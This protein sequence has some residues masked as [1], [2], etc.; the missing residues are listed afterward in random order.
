[1]K[2]LRYLILALIILNLPAATL[3]FGGGGF[4]SVLSY[5]SLILMMIF[6]MFS[7]K[8]KANVWMLII[9]F[10][11]YLISA[12]QYNGDLKI[13]ITLF[14]KY[15]IVVICG[16]EVIK[17]TSKKELFYF[18]T[19]G[20]LSILIH[21]LFFTSDYGRYSGFYINPNVGGFICITGYGLT[22]GLENK[23]LK[24][25]GQFLFTLMG[26][27]TFSR[28]FIALWLL[29]N[30]L[31]IFISIKNIRI[32]VLG[33]MIM[34]TLFVID[35]FIGLNNPRFQQL[36]AIVSNE[37]VDS[38]A[39]NQGSRTETW[40]RFYDYILDK[41][42]FGNGYGAFQGGGVH[43]LGSHNTYLLVIGESG[44]IPF[45][46][47]IGL[48]LFMLYKGLLLYRLAPNILMQGIGISVFLMANHNFFN[49]YY[50]TFLSMWLQHQ[51]I[52]YDKKVNSTN[53]NLLQ[54]S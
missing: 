38:K 36:K 54:T 17:Q 45:L 12:F 43:R 33:A 37:N 53:N 26:L 52:T 10:S 44:I 11:Y 7:R 48:F 18:L 40:A 13:Y 42:F 30:A 15:F 47:F 14:L 4:G 27:L 20:A 5:A 9:G 6:F 21:T 41:P 34:S 16:Y 1:M 29:L 19:V 3:K 2:L 28:T 51:I 39:I 23:K 31:S 50:I 32:F 46:I 24:I 49:F 22:Y 35:E 8:G 25:I